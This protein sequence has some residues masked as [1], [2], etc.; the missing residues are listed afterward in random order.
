MF[1]GG[2]ARVEGRVGEGGGERRRRR[3]GRRRRRNWK[4][5]QFYS[6][7]KNKT[8]EYKIRV[9]KIVKQTLNPFN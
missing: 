4:R 3:K 8:H 5:R 9:Q 2:G 6:N 7:C 1:R